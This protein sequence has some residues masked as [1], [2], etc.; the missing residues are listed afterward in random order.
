MRRWTLRPPPPAVA[1]AMRSLLQVLLD[2][3]LREA[4]PPLQHNLG[5]DKLVRLI[6]AGQANASLFRQLVRTLSSAE[7]TLGGRPALAEHVAKHLVVLVAH[8]RGWDAQ[9]P[10]LDTETLRARCLAAR[11]KVVATVTGGSPDDFSF[12]C[13][14]DTHDPHALG[15]GA[16][17]DGFA[18]WWSAV[19][20]SFTVPDVFGEKLE[21][22]FNFNEIEFRAAVRPDASSDV[23]TAFAAVDAARHRYVKEIVEGLGQHLEDGGIW[24]VDRD[25]RNNKLLWKKTKVALLD[26]DAVDV[27]P[28]HGL[29]T[30]RDRDSKLIASAVSTVQLEC[31]HSEYLAA[32][33]EARFAAQAELQAL[34]D[35]IAQPEILQACVA[36]VKLN[37]IFLATSLHAMEA[38]RC[39]WSLPPLEPAEDMELTKL[40]P[41]LHLSQ[42]RPYW[43]GSDEAVP[44][45][46]F[47]DGQWLLTG[48]N[49]SGKSTVLRAVTAAALLANCG[50]PC[51]SATV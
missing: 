19:C 8:D 51:T 25:I 16:N 6:E 41:P 38:L 15:C 47:L 4:L 35:E 10:V 49:M 27:N 48:P 43:L 11:E 44:N 28:D 14:K 3:M 20:R 23:A 36:A 7:Q 1:D 33:E 40:P 22:F 18:A 17:T 9:D 37:V 50:V 2:D 42:L 24:L 46:V 39:N 12:I 45:D 32:C 21:G 29:I 31:V 34:C 26:K 5:E 13:T 30:P